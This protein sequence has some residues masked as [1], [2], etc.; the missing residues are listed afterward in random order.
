MYILK[1]IKNGTYYIG[2]TVNLE[3]RIQEHNMGLSRF[4]ATFRPW[5]IVYEESYQ[6]LGEVR[7]REKQLKSW[8]KRKALETLIKSTGPI[9]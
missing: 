2:S 5:K 3:R 7:K 4:T 8:K 9:V 6:S 1:S